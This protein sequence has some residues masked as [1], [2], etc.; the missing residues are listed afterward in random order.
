MARPGGNPD[1]AKLGR[2]WQPGQ[3]GN[4]AGDPTAGKREKLRRMLIESVD[5]AQFA[6]IIA[7]M[8]CEA[9]KGN[10]AALKEALD[11]LLGKDA[12]KLGIEQGEGGGLQIVIRPAEPPPGREANG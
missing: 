9:E 2:R 11:R 5:E 12:G 4:P 8:L 1:I 3:S 6:R 7:K 10:M